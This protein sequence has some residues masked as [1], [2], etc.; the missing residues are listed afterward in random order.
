MLRA[1]RS[2]ECLTQLGQGLE[3]ERLNVVVPLRDPE[4]L[5]AGASL[6]R[7]VFTFRTR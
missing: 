3:E 4:I 6:R 2:P 7:A 1:C 5:V